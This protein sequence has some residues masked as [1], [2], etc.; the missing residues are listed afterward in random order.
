MVYIFHSFTYNLFVSLNLKYISYRQHILGSQFFIHSANICLSIGDFNPLT[1]NAIT[2]KI[3]FIDTI[4][5]GRFCI[6]DVFFVLLLPS[7]MLNR[8]FLAY[9]FNSFV[10]STLCSELFP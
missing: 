6:Y 5:L 9:Y 8:Y 7:F 1:F 2:D 4:L 10:S 3:G